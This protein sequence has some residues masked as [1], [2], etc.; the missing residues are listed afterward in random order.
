MHFMNEPR[1]KS[2]KIAPWA[3][4]KT[5]LLGDLR[6]DEEV[7]QRFVGRVGREIPRPLPVGVPLPSEGCPRL[8]GPHLAIELLTKEA[9]DLQNMSVIGR[10]YI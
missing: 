7:H 10:F 9:D 4:R 3:I 1:K 5:H 2:L 6:P 8:E